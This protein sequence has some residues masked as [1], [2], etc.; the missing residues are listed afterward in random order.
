ML[1]FVPAA[2]FTLDK[3]EDH[4]TSYKF[5]RR[6]ID[7]LF[8]KTCGIKSF[9]RGKGPDGAEMVAVNVRCLDDVDLATVPTHAF[10]G[11]SL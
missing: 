8:C 5:H 3:G 9:G 6:H 10:D 7:H 2:K 1:S 11:K 4:L